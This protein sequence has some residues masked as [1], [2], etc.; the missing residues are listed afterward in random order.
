MYRIDSATLIPGSGAPIPDATVLLDEGV[1]AYA[2]PTARLPADA[3]SQADATVPY[4]MP[5]MWDVHCHLAGVRTWTMQQMLV[6]PTA[7]AAARAAKDAE[8]ALQA[9]FTSLR[10]TGGLG[11]WL[12]PVIDEGTIAGPTVY[13]AG[14]VLSP[15]GGHADIHELP[16]DWVGN[17]PLSSQYL[18]TADGVDECLRAVRLQLRNNARVIKICA[19][20]GVAS[21]V[22]HPVHQQFSPAE[23]RAIVEEAARADRIVMAHCHGKPG[24]MAALEA[25]VH[26][27]EHGSYVDEEAARAM[28]EADAVLV[29]TRT[30]VQRMLDGK[31]SLPV[32]TYEKVVALA[33][34]HLESIAIAH[35]AGVTIAAGT[36]VGTS[37]AGTFLPW[38]ANGTE[39]AL[40]Q[41]AGLTALEAIE[42]VTANGPLTLG[43]QAPKSGRLQAGYDADLIALSADPITDTTVLA[44]PQ[45]ITHV[46]KNGRLAKAL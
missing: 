7:T 12:A 34:R 39:P 6:T 24:I 1:I 2:G 32:T 17:H 27:I 10:E 20:G 5:G 41:Q 31:E 42:A 16:H 13:A 25:G 36:D 43:P 28:R 29:P 9:G 18:L 14:A 3:P 22:D 19:S 23:M 8:A 37:G 35:A 40:L 44:D 38:G 30:I 26:T 4:L 33:D 45:N 21:T 46:W 11:V 15:T